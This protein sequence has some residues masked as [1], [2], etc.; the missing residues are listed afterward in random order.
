MVALATGCGGIRVVLT[1]LRRG[2]FFHNLEDVLAELREVQLLFERGK[3]FSNG[4][5]VGTRAGLRVVALVGFF[6]LILLL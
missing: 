3:R 6:I 2:G 4:H 1:P 5:K